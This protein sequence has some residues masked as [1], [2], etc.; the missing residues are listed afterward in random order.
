MPLRAS[1]HTVA[2]NEIDLAVV[3][4]GNMGLAIV[5]GALAASIVR[6][7]R[8][9]VID[10]S[11]EAR[12]RAA[13]LGVRIASD[14][15]KARGAAHLLLAVKPQS[16]SDVARSI[17]PLPPSREVVSVVSGWSCARIAAALGMP[18]PD[19]VVRAMPNLGASIGRSVTALAGSS[20][21]A[22]RLFRSIGD[23]VPV[24]ESLLDAVT[25]VS[26]SGPAYAFLLAESMIDAAR[27]LGFDEP[28]ANRLVIGT[29][30]GAAA[31]L[32]ADDRSPKAW[33]AAV[34]SKGGTTE[35]AARVWNERGVPKAIVD[36]IRAAH[37]RAGELG[38]Q[39][40]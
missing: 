11:K 1:R 26:G 2:V 7:E 5:R 18:T 20:D 35:A 6:P 15:T 4:C 10:A 40:Q 19:R 34:T 14:L 23:V 22:E 21:F 28:T 37:A 9:L 39:A 25:A 8:V 24:P 13:A 36:A 12:E 27:A 3:G 33:R 16:V 38:A 30:E 32:R 17:A 31:L 29:L